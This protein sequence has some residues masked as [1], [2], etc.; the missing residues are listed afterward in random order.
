MSQGCAA[1]WAGPWLRLVV[2]SPIALLCGQMLPALQAN[3]PSPPASHLLP[4]S[5]SPRFA[6]HRA[7][8]DRIKAEVESWGLK[9]VPT[10]R[11]H[12]AHTLTAAYLPEGITPAMVGGGEGTWRGEGASI[13]FPAYIVCG[14]QGGEGARG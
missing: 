11:D 8:S 7:V 13:H 5:V 14:C 3:H 9:L 2:P 12:A 10:H 4:L 1:G 6:K